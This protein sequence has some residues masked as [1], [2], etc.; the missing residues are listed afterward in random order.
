MAMFGKKKERQTLTYD[1]EKVK[2]VLHVSICTGETAA[3]FMD[4]KT[5]RFEERQLIT[6]ERDLEQ[7]RRAWSITGELE[8]IY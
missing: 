6:C 5:G 2:P 4:L 1:A 7:F 3:G 8:R